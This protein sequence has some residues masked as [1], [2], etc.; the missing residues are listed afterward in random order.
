MMKIKNSTEANGRVFYELL[1]DTKSEATKIG[2][3][4]I[5]IW[6]PGYAPDV[7][8]PILDGSGTWRSSASRTAERD[9]SLYDQAGLREAVIA[10]RNAGTYRFIH[11]IWDE[12]ED[13]EHIPVSPE[14]MKLNQEEPVSEREIAHLHYCEDFEMSYYRFPSICFRAFDVAIGSELGLEKPWID[15]GY[16]VEFQYDHGPGDGPGNG[17]FATA[18]DALTWVYQRFLER[19][20]ET[21]Y[22]ENFAPVLPY[23]AS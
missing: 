12:R 11:G 22:A 17:P 14:Q 15:R 21:S 5:D 9:L 10:Q 23:G 13:L 18:D 1:G 19:P 3:I 8:P 7:E 4:F 6:G 2:Q 20:S 16:Y